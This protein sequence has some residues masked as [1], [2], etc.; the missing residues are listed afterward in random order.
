MATKDKVIIR[1]IARETHNG[2][3]EGISATSNKI[4]ISAISI[5]RIKND[6]I[7]EERENVDF[8]SLMMQLGMEL[9]TKEK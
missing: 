5:I 9:K 2:E 7:V 1:L 4:E 3:F 6:K 8:L